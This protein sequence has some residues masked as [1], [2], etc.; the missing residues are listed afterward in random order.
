VV[1][2]QA[3]VVA[4]IELCGVAAKVRF[5]EVVIGSDHAALED[6]KEV[7]GGVAVLPTARGDILLR[8]VVDL[9]VVG[10]LATDAD[11]DRRFVGHESRRAINV[12]DQQRA[13]G[14]GGDVGDVERANLPVT[15]DQCDNGFLGLHG[16]CGAVLLL[17]ADI[18]FVGFHNAVRTAQRGRVGRLHGFPNAVAHEPCGFVGDADH[19]GDLMGAHALLAGHKQVIDQQPLIERHL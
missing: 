14:F 5:R 17:P 16:A 9:A 18:G 1:V 11:I 19:A 13:K 6:R 12:S 3:R 2:Q 7:F 15:L 10:E 4:E 8:A